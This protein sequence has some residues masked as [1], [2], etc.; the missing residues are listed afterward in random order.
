MKL[1]GT[2][3][4]STAATQPTAPAAT[5]SGNRPRAQRS[6][7]RRSFSGML[8]K[9]T[10]LGRSPKAPSSRAA[11]ESLQQPASASVGAGEN[12]RSGAAPSNDDVVREMVA[13]I[14]SQKDARRPGG[15]GTSSEAETRP[16]IAHLLAPELGISPSA[17]EKRSK[18][19]WSG[20]FRRLSSSK[21]TPAVTQKTPTQAP[22]A[23]L[24]TATR[25]EDPVAET[26]SWIKSQR[27]AQ[28]PVQHDGHETGAVVFSSTGDGEGDGD[29][30][31]RHESPRNSNA[32]AHSA[33]NVTQDDGPIFDESGDEHEEDDLFDL[34]IGPL[35]APPVNNE[36]HPVTPSNSET[37]SARHDVPPQH[38]EVSTTTA[39]LPQPDPAPSAQQ[40]R[41]ALDKLKQLKNALKGWQTYAKDEAYIHGFGIS[42]TSLSLTPISTNTRTAR[43]KPF[44]GV[45]REGDAPV[46]LHERLANLPGSTPPAVLHESPVVQ[47]LEAPNALD[48]L[49]LDASILPGTNRRQL[50]DSIKQVAAEK[51][52]TPFEASSLAQALHIAFSRTPDRSSDAAYDPAYDAAHDAQIALQSLPQTN[53]LDALRD[54]AEPQ[55]PPDY[56]ADKAWALAQELV[57]IPG[58]VGT[59]LIEKLTPHTPRPAG[60]H[61]SVLEKDRMLVSVLLKASQQVVREARQSVNPKTESKVLGVFPRASRQVGNA[62]SPTPGGPRMLAHDP[63]SIFAD[64][65]LHAAIAQAGEDHWPGSN[66]TPV[67]SNL[68]LAQKAMLAVKDEL[69]TIDAHVADAATRGTA[70]SQGTHGCRFAISMIRGDMMTDQAREPSGV[71]SQFQLAESRLS[72]S[73]GKH[74][75]RAMR[76]PTTWTRFLGSLEALSRHVGVYKN[77]SPFYT[78]NRIAENDGGRGM[79]VV[80][81]G[82][83]HAGRALYD[84]Q[85]KVQTTIDER[86]KL[87]EDAAAGDDEALRLMVRSSIIQM[88]KAETLMLPRFA[89]PVRLSDLS[90][91]N[92]VDA[93]MQKLAGAGADTEA[94]DALRAKVAAMVA[95]ENQP[96]TTQRLLQWAAAVGGP[97][98]AG[99]AK[100]IAGSAPADHPWRA[101]AEA[102]ERAEHPDRIAPIATPSLRGKSRE[103]V[104]E[105]L[106]KIVAAEELGSGFALDSAG[107]VQGTTKNISGIISSIPLHFLGSAHVD[108]GGGK[109]RTVRFESVTSTDRSQLRVSVTTLKRAQG[110]VGGSIGHFTS[111]DAPITVGGGLDLGGAY[112][113]VHQEGAVLGFPRNL[114][115]GVLGD[116]AVNEKKAQLVKLLVQGGAL[117]G[118]P[119]PANEEDRKSL[120][121]CAYQAFGDDLSIGFYEMDQTDTQGTLSVNGN[122]GIRFGDFKLG[123]PTLGAAGRGQSATIRYRDQSGFLKTEW[124]TDSTAYNASFQGSLASLNGYDQLSAGTQ[125][126]HSSISTAIAPFVSGSAQFFR[127]GVADRRVRIMQDG[128]ELPTSFATRTF[129]APISFLHE[130]GQNVDK[131]ADDKAKKYF[132][133]EYNAGG[134]ARENVVLREKTRML[135]FVNHYLKERDLT[136]TPQLYTEFGDNVDTANKLHA[137]AYM[138]ERLGNKETARTAREEI[139]AIH[140][141][142]KYREG[143]F[144]TNLQIE[145]EGKQVGINGIVGVTYARNDNRSQQVLSFT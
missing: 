112:E 67:P 75:D 61:A 115:G 60:T 140:G 123:L 109:I 113:V 144:L 62:A 118:Y 25:R 17:P 81:R 66:N 14:V 142:E 135:E 30:E 96:L 137:A 95:Q 125:D 6:S 58:G 101:F 80:N 108:L 31:V 89:Q 119:Q 83:T 124:E 91:G 19:G 65:A 99:S 111:G 116:R 36:I 53:L 110:G 82:G 54:T 145:Q 49:F 27:A 130:F 72:K 48:R 37:G 20:L 136:S 77:K 127:F 1:I 3:A 63:A 43:A 32:S 85:H 15:A 59:S 87:G 5:D 71:R 128:K 28:A 139:S 50:F 29:T 52:L 44:T 74:L 84:M 38:N 92:V 69:Q 141:D 13:R 121:K 133:K 103:E 2:S 57:H 9:L 86:A 73:V 102:F 76:R 122:V 105:I 12:R 106:A 21:K 88:S 70:F 34:D 22:P 98:N 97:D 47:E 107:N 18:K 64:G 4:S 33:K 93:V 42:S 35:H 129:Q 40:Q 78:Y 16:T 120:I 26:V 41:G 94:N 114:S 24:S 138:A 100:E 104:S 7:G 46:K 55:R 45:T 132:P 10:R 51:N 11:G 117:E 126:L 68:S 134:Q 56:D 79:G 39:P 8:S 23:G 90:Q 143:R 131:Y